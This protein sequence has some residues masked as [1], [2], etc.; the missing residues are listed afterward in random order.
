MERLLGDNT[1]HANGPLFRELFLQRLPANV[2][3]VLAS[4]AQ[5]FS[6]KELAERAD[7]VMEASISTSIS[8]VTPPEHSELYT[9]VNQLRTEVS[10]LKRLLQTT[11]SRQNIYRFGDAAQKC[12]PPCSK[13]GNFRARH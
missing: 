13:A 7:K 8:F 1:E 11:A 4:L 2:R 12:K 10:D 6:L 5:T 9:E 3:M